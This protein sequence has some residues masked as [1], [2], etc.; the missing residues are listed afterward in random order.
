M[1][2]ALFRYEWVDALQHDSCEC[3]T[4]HNC[5]NLPYGV[6]SCNSIHHASARQ[7]RIVSSCMICFDSL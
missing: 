7:C 2:A 5:M 4:I 1:G 3:H 6:V